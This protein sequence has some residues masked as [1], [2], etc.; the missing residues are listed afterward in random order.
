[1]VKD[2]VHSNEVKRKTESIKQTWNLRDDKVRFFQHIM[3][4]S[5]FVHFNHTRRTSSLHCHPSPCEIC[6]CIAI[7]CLFIHDYHKFKDSYV[8]GLFW[9]SA[10]PHLHWFRLGILLYLQEDTGELYYLAMEFPNSPR[11][12]R[13][14]EFSTKCFITRFSLL[15]LSQDKKRTLSDIAVVRKRKPDVRN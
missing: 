8:W 1:M 11:E 6:E 15:S 2:Q 13:V 7:E 14:L 9:L 12:K 3:Q 10:C 5:S 4:G